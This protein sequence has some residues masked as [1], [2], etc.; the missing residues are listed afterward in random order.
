MTPEALATH[1]APASR[2][3]DGEI[4]RQARQVLQT[5][6]LQQLY[7]AVTEVVVILNAHRQIVFSNRNLAEL[8]RAKD[9]SEFHGLRP[10]EALGCAHAAECEGGCGAAESCATCGALR[11]ILS[12]LDGKKSIQEC[13]VL[14]AS[15]GDA[16]DLLVR[17]SPLDLDGE[18]F[19]IVALT[20]ISHEKR[21][22]ALERVFFHDIINTTTG[23]KMLSTTLE[24]TTEGQLRK[25]AGDIRVAVERLME[26]IN[27][28]RDLTSAESRDLA[29]RPIF[30]N[31]RE[32]LV[33]LLAAYRHCQVTGGCRLEIDEGCEDM[34]FKSDC[35]I[36][37][38]VLGNMVKNAVEASGPGDR[39]AVSCRRVADEVEF[40]V[41]NPGCIPEDVQLQIFKRSFSTKGPGRGLGTYSIKLL[42]ER[43]LQGAAD[44]TSSPGD[45]TTFTVRI[46]LAI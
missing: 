6:M 39:V 13:R 21:R 28:Q 30:M 36:L 41:R 5:G 8:L 11:A 22:R 23:L 43:Y 33:E 24:R 27:S 32:F 46:P 10:G 16:L 26:E 40:S 3:S 17:A 4:R 19:T 35:T 31:S 34:P 9:T 29:V 25:M 2:A 14:R 42:T 44:F 37:S 45:G 1:F 20:D 18:R 15:G 12:G 7:D 38:R